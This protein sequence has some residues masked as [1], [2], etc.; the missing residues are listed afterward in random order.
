MKKER[1][2]DPG[3]GL[4]TLEGLEDPSTSKTPHLKSWQ[5]RGVRVPPERDG[6]LAD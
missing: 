1:G 3:C 2:E 4:E 5:R 6:K